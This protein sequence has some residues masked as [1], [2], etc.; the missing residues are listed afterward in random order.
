MTDP[1]LDPNPY[2]TPPRQGAP[3]AAHE[4]ELAPV[5]FRAGLL[6]TLAVGVFPFV[7]ALI[8]AAVGELPPPTEWLA[9]QGHHGPWH[10]QGVL[11]ELILAPMMELFLFGLV[12]A[13]LSLVLA[14]FRGR[15][16]IR[17]LGGLGA[18]QLALFVAQMFLLYWIVD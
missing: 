16:I 14:P 7:V 6:L 15:R 4:R 10:H 17:H 3:E 1:A 2:R 5:W 11:K 12:S 18:L 8:G 13:P 9:Y